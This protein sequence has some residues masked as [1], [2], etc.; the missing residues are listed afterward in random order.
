MES[1]PAIVKQNA[2][3]NVNINNDRTNVQEIGDCSLRAIPAIRG[4][5]RRIKGA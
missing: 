3:R 5:T 4:M 1:F 2:T